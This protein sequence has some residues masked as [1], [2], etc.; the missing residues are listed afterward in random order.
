MSRKKYQKEYNEKIKKETKTIGK[1]S[2]CKTE[3]YQKRKLRNE[4]DIVTEGSKVEKEVDALGKLT[5]ESNS[6]CL[7][8]ELTVDLDV[9]GVHMAAEIDTGARSIRVNPEWLTAQGGVISPSHVKAGGANQR[10]L[11]FAGEGVLSFRLRGKFFKNYPVKVLP[12]L[13]S[14]VLIGRSFWVKTLLRL[15]LGIGEGSICVKG[16]MFS[17]HVRFAE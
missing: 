5:S 17:G 10:P 3:K 12:G 4:L 9:N 1:R 2:K 7:L 14:D 16:K 13:K 11:T 8:D 6:T 15:D